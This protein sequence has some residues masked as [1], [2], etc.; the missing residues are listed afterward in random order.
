MHLGQ[1]VDLQS[2]GYFGLVALLAFA[3]G[4]QAAT[5]THIGPLTIYTTFVTGTLAKFS[6]AFTRSLFWS[7]DQ[8]NNGTCMSDIVRHAPQQ[9]HVQDGHRWLQSG[10]AM[11]WEQLWEPLLRGQDFLLR[12]QCAVH[13]SDNEGG[14]R[15]LVRWIARS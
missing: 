13:V 9:R 15:N 1:I 10:F 14:R 7:Y 12:H 11:W 4:V 2:P 8:F 6:E 3:M 5:L